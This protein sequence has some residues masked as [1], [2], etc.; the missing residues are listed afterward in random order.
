MNEQLSKH[1]QLLLH[2]PKELMP[3]WFIQP[4]HA[5]ADSWLATNMS[6]YS[7]LF[8]K[9]FVLYSR[10]NN[11]LSIFEYLLVKTKEAFQKCLC[12]TGLNRT[13]CLQ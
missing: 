7:V 2:T 1:C 6:R 10:L 4:Q 9:T 3:D 12:Y 11:T 5:L 8:S 13:F